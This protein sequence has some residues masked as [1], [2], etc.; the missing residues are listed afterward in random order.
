VQTVPSANRTNR[1]PGFRLAR[2][3]PDANA[4]NNVISI[5]TLVTQPAIS[6]ADVTVT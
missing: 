5:S 1:Q 3:K 4:A 2:E 6:I